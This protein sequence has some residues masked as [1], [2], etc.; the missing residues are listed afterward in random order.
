M[1]A[2]TLEHC[3]ARVTTACSAASALRALQAEPPQVIISDIGLPGDDGF[4]LLRQIRALPASRGGG[5]PAI[6]LTGRERSEDRAQAGGEG[7]QEHLTKPV[8]TEHMLAAIA[9]V[10]AATATR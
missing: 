1:L 7:F 6:A 9:R 2:M 3:G 10:L 5:I 8:T 4:S